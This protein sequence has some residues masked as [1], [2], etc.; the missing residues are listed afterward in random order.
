MI[1]E[2]NPAGRLHKLLS[3]AKNQPDKITVADAWAKV[4]GCKNDPV[5]VTE[6]V[7]QIYSLSQETQSLIRMRSELNHNLYLSSFN[8]LEQAFFPLNLGSPWQT[9]KQYLTDD[10][11]AR[12]QFC[13]EALSKFYSEE[14]LSE[15]DLQDIID[16]TDN[17]FNLL[18]E[19]SLPDSIKLILLEEIERIRN[20][21]IMYRIKGAKGL[22]Q[23]L[24]SAI[25][26]VIANQ[27]EL[28]ASTGPNK[29]IIQRLGELLDKL[30]LFTS[31]AMKLQRILVNTTKPITFLIRLINPKAEPNNEKD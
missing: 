30:D 29:D 21:L 23:A 28:K 7:V 24:Q 1:D 2:S 12:L 18:Y 22:K 31:R 6:A 19:S 26:A 16:K 3:N 4:I 11:L 5:Q 25:G 15:K 17:L 20:A 10:A 13:A 9:A 14:S 8:K 27:E